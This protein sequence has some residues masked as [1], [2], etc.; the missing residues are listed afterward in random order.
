MSD[1]SHEAA[2]ASW[3]VPTRGTT[4]PCPSWR[5]SS[6]TSCC[7]IQRCRPPPGRAESRSGVPGVS[8]AS[9]VAGSRPPQREPSF[10]RC[11]L[12]GDSR[13]KEFGRRRAFDGNGATVAPHGVDEFATIDHPHFVG[14]GF[15]G[16][17]IH[18]RRERNFR[19][20][21]RERLSVEAPIDRLTLQP[22]I[23]SAR[24]SLAPKG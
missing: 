24:A 10:P 4:S 14:F 16:A 19:R 6:S 3:R 11:L 21:D 7:A 5:C 2:G 1:A 9:A 23:Q 20:A 12:A 13:T 8:R 22:A 15:C 18:R 17:A